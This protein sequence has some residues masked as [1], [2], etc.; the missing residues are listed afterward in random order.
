MM[1]RKACQDISGSGNLQAKELAEMLNEGSLLGKKPE[2]TF[3]NMQWTADA[4][5]LTDGLSSCFTWDWTPY[6]LK[7]LLVLLF[8]QLAWRVFFFQNEKFAFRWSKVNAGPS[9]LTS[10]QQAGAVQDGRD[11][12]IAAL[13]PTLPLLLTQEEVSQEFLSNLEHK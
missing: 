5:G 7:L 10:L 12:P 9:I 1:G 11:A 2:V 13:C 8:Y 6:R 4:D 3:T